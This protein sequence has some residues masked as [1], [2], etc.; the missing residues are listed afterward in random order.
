MRG[1][2]PIIAIIILLLITVAIAG[3]AFSYITMYYGGLT[4]K[5]IE[6]TGVATCTSGSVKIPIKNSGTSD[7]SMS[8]F[9]FTRDQPT[10]TPAGN[11][12]TGT[13]SVGKL[14]YIN[15]TGCGAGNYCKYS[16]TV[17]GRT[18]SPMVQC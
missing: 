11:L 8:E 12:W 6:V 1:I 15:D 3:V 2:T 9:T 7:I 17:A 14:I 10:G 18:T 13:L 5:V 4:N 16:I